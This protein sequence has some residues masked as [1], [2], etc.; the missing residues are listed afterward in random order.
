VEVSPLPASEQFGADFDE[1]LLSLSLSI[2]IALARVSLVDLS[3]I[4]PVGGAD[5]SKYS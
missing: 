4:S 3:G 2:I 5:D 1:T